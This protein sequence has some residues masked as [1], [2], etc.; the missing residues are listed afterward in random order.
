MK[1]KRCR[2]CGADTSKYSKFGL[3][4]RCGN[5]GKYNPRYK[6]GDS[7][8]FIKRLGEEALRNAGVAKQC[9]IDSKHNGVIDIHHRDGNRKNNK[10][11]NLLYLC[12][13]C[14][15]KI[16]NFFEHNLREFI[17][18]NSEKN[19][20]RISVIFTEEFLRMQ[21]NIRGKI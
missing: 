18:K 3:C 7:A 21:K 9:L 19:S 11:S 20:E 16:H 15:S 1:N 2:K 5:L 12:H 4:R 14:H 8:G 13:T 17:N 6:N 10:S